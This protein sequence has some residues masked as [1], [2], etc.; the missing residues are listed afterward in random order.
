MNAATLTKGERNL[1]HVRFPCSFVLS[2]CAFG[3]GYQLYSPR[4]FL[5]SFFDSRVN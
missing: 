5:L 2:R 3:P 1:P 4:Y